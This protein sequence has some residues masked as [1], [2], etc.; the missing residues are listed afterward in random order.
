MNCPLFHSCSFHALTIA[1][2]NITLNLL[3]L[4]A[5]FT[6]VATAVGTF[7]HKLVKESYWLNIVK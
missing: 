6:V 3:H 2:D 5:P 1:F 7:A 4:S